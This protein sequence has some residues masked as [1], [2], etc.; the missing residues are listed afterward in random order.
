MSIQLK[1]CAALDD[2]CSS[3]FLFEKTGEYA[4]DNT[5][6][7]GAPNPQIIHATS[8]VVDVLYAGATVPVSLNVFVGLPGEGLPTNLVDVPYEITPA[9]CG[10]TEWP[11]GPLQL[12]YSVGGIYLSQPFTAGPISTMV[13]IDCGY[14]CCV[15]KKLRDIAKQVVSGKCSCDHKNVLEV[16]FLDTVLEAAELATCCGNLTEAN[17]NFNYVKSKC[18]PGACGCPA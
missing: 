2:K 1:I 4:S 11:Q 17:N 12:T 13:I 10:L 9:M 5:G 16:M 14:K 6:G 7:W 3:I 15:E 18:S 8:A